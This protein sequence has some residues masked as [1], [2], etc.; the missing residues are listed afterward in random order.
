M[1]FCSC[2]SVNIDSSLLICGAYA[3]PGMFYPE[4]KGSVT[5]C[6]VLEED[7]YGRILF[8]YTAPNVITDKNE[9]V[10]IICQK[11]TKE[12]VYFYE[13][14][15]YKLLSENSYDLSQLKQS[16]DW[17]QPLNE[18]K[19]TYRKKAVSYDNVI[20]TGSAF[21]IEKIKDICCK[22]FVVNSSDIIELC[23]DD[24]K[25]NG[26]SVFYI[27]FLH[28]GNL[29]KIFLSINEKYDAEFLELS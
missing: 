24:V 6:D 11:N 12:N 16:N 25:P 1:F 29:E 18:N 27:E 10:A 13:N 3:V 5:S 20:I 4:I 19:M 22:H 21:D 9:T 14:D 8:L 17:N 2:F 23:L 26:T 15:C 7:E 28:N